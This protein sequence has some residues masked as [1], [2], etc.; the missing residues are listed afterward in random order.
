MPFWFPIST[1]SIFGCRLCI[2]EFD[3]QLRRWTYLQGR[4]GRKKFLWVKNHGILPDV[5]ESDSGGFMCEGTLGSV[6][7]GIQFEIFLICIYVFLIYIALICLQNLLSFQ[8]GTFWGY[9]LERRERILFIY[10][11]MKF[12]YREQWISYK[13]KKEPRELLSS[14]SPNH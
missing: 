5:I 6:M 11:K 2:H 9:A 1:S 14:I 7:F 13:Y 8:Y 3:R 12:S 4:H 10:S